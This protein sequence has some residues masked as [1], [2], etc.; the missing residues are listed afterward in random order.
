ME[1]VDRSR[2]C[3][4]EGW[5]KWTREGAAHRR[6]SLQFLCGEPGSAVLTWEGNTLALH[7]L[8]PKERKVMA[9]VCG[10]GSGSCSS[11]PSVVGDSL[12]LLGASPVF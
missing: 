3:Q 8:D 12:F 6:W 7:L 11:L 10:Y 1:R 2:E 5:K 9:L 4:A